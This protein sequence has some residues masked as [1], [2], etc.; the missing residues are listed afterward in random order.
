[1]LTVVESPIF[2]RLWPRYWDEEER[3][4]FASFIAVNPDAGSVIRGSGGVRK[5]RWT[6]ECPGKSGGMRIVY[7]TRSEAG[8]L[9]LLTLYAKS[10]SENISLDT[11]KELRRALEI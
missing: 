6:R 7:L 10:T 1:M 11:L 3:A 5:V 4:G 2:Q 8:E 9:D